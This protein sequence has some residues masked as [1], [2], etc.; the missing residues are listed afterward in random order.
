[1][2]TA[3]PLHLLTAGI[4][5]L[6]LAACSDSDGTPPDET[7]DPPG[8]GG[9]TMTGTGGTPS[10]AGAPATG[11]GGTVTPGSTV[12]LMP[13]ATGWV[14]GTDNSVGIQG[15]W[16]SYNDCADSPGAC[17]MNH[18]PPEGE[19]PNMGGSMCTS[20][21]TAVVAAEAEFSMKWGAGIALDL[22]NSGGTM[23]VKMPYN[24]DMNGVIGFSFTLTGTAPGLR[25]NFTSPAVGDNSHFVTAA[26]GAQDALFSEAMQGSWVTAKTELDTTQILAIQFQIPSALSRS[27]AFDFCIENLA[28]LTE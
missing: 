19:F 1:M 4:L 11:G 16:Y 24:A 21:A 5:S 7:G 15:A 18:L 22:N 8:T 14:Q 23:G 28:A 26:T 6:G 13:D 17:T 10:T 3:K 25:V 27:V 12:A 2:K 9:T 20:G